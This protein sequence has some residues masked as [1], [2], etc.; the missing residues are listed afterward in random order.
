MSLIDRSRF[1]ARLSG[2]IAVSL[3]SVAQASAAVIAASDCLPPLGPHF[4][5]VGDNHI[6]F[7]IPGLVVDLS[8]VV[9]A[10]FTNCLAPPQSGSQLETFGSSV[11]FDLSFNG[12]PA[13]PQ[14]APATVSVNVSATGTPGVFDTEMVQLDIAGGTLPSAVRVRES[15]TLQ[16]LGRTTVEDLGGGLYRIDSFFDIFTELSLDG[17]QNWL[18]ATDPGH[19]TLT[20]PEPGSLALVGLA[21]A[22]LAASRRRRA[23]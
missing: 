12:G 7:Q 13:Q 11:A 15:P 21:M 14:S 22:G 2:V 4:K 18:P 1:V 6:I 17:G 16:S 9:H 23:I 20:V 5:Y 19:V 3:L 8:N 10:G